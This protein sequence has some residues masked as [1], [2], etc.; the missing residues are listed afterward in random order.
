MLVGHRNHKLVQRVVDG[1][2]FGFSLKYNG[3]RLNRQPRNLPTVFTHSKELWQSVM[4]EVNLGRMLGMFQMQPIFPLICSPVG[5]V[6][7]KNSTAMCHI[8]HLSHPQGFSINSFIAP[9]DAEMHYQSFHAAIQLVASQGRGAHMTKEDFKSAFC[10]VPMRY[11]DLNLLG[12]KAQ[13]QFFIEFALPFG[14]SVSCA[15]FKDISTLIHWIVEKRVGL[16]FIHY[17]DDFLMVNRYANI[18]SQT[19]N[20]LKQV[21]EEIQMPIAPEKSEGPSTVIE[22]LGLT[23]DIDNMVI[24]IPQDKLQD[25]AQIITKMVKTRKTMSWELQSLAGKLNFVIKVVPAG[26]CFIKCIYQAQVGVLHHQHIDLSSPVLSDLHIWKVFLAK[27]R[28]WM[29]IMDTKVLHASAIGVFTDAVGNVKLGWG[30]WL[31]H[32]GLWM[33]SQLEE[34]FFQKF[35]PSIDFLELYALLATIVTW[36]PHLM[37]HAILFQLDNTSTVFA[38]RNKSSN[39]NQMLF[40]LHFL[41]QFCMAHN[42]TVLA[43]HV[44]GIH[45]MICDKLSHFQFQDFHAL[46]P[47]HTACLPLI[48]SD[49]IAPVSICMQR[50][51][52]F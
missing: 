45:N 15:T 43:R 18:C 33:Y 44:H 21:C 48:P 19:M 2:H 36:A 35:Q 11:Q 13:G 24:H 50:V 46:K 16:K 52:F 23:L 9:E 26:K 14:A 25:I 7:K 1:F 27:F 41:T 47:D 29:P 6:E 49:L 3:P 20:V 12:I 28:G 5:M 17:L 42:I 38:L 30:A 32:L 10:N 8:T 22:F 40:L 39:S 34:D 51:S 4:E 31:P 37:D